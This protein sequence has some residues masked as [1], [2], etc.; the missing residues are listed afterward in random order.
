MGA[1]TTMT[2]TPSFSLVSRY[3]SIPIIKMFLDVLDVNTRPSVCTTL[4]CVG[5]TM[6][7]TKKNRDYLGILVMQTDTTEHLQN[8]RE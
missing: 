2:Q 4:H 3:D 7:R 6:S 5:I 1:L 8:A